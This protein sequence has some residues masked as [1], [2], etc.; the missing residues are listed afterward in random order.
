MDYQII[1]FEVIEQAFLAAESKE[2][3]YNIF[4]ASAT[5]RLDSDI[6]QSKGDNLPP[7]LQSLTT[8]LGLNN[9]KALILIMSLHNLLKQYI[10][11]GS[12]DEVTF[13]EKFPEGFKKSLKSFIFKQMR[14]VAPLMRTFVQDEFTSTSKMEDF[15]WRLDFKVSSK[16]QERMK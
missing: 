15:D 13:A 14:E 2:A 8:D 7:Q 4:M 12:A 5:G 6:S 16:Q 10:G 11:T 3:L 9:E 1:N